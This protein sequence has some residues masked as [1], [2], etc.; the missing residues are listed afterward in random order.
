MNLLTIRTSNLR[1][2]DMLLG[3][4][5]LKFLYFRTRR[6]AFEL[7]LR[8]RHDALTP[9]GTNVLLKLSH[10]TVRQTTSSPPNIAPITELRAS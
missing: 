3:V 5:L 6:Y 8:W 2:R 10:R 4:G 9:T 7:A 1:Y